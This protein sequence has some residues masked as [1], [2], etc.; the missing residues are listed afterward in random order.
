MTKKIRSRFNQ[1]R[2]FSR[3]PGYRNGRYGGA[4]ARHD[5]GDGVSD[6]RRLR[7][8]NGEF[9]Q[10]LI[11]AFGVW[12]V[13]GHFIAA[14]QSVKEIVKAGMSQ[15]EHACLFPCAS[16]YGQPPARPL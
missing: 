3:A 11:Q 1:L 8:R 10:Q 5:I 16:A 15:R 2:R 12:F 13:M 6:I 9:A 7:W 14:Q 4:V